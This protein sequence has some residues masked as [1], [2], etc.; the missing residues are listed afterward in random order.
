M[1]WSSFQT[2][3]K[4]RC[5]PLSK[6][7]IHRFVCTPWHLKTWSMLILHS[8]TGY[9][10][11]LSLYQYVIYMLFNFFFQNLKLFFNL[12]FTILDF[13]SRYNRVVRKNLRPGEEKKR[14]R[15][16][17]MTLSWHWADWAVRAQRKKNLNNGEP[18]FP[19]QIICSSFLLK[20]FVEKPGSGMLLR[21]RR[22]GRALG[23]LTGLRR[24][25]RKKKIKDAKRK[26]KKR[27]KVSRS[28]KRENGETCN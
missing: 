10:L 24:K 20:A 11:L 25:K 4:G 2:S 28:L 1:T 15:Q 23:F 6:I 17:C 14:E 9:I 7:N 27:F 3:H 16:I 12:C 5:Y 8:K 22:A 19:S 13:C 26:K 21:I 18:I